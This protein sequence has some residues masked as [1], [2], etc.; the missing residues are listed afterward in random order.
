MIRSPLAFV[1]LLLAFSAS[2]VFAQ[3]GNIFDNLFQQQRQQQ[4]PNQPKADGSW[5]EETYDN[6]NC[7]G[8]ICEDTLACV[9]RPVDCPC[10]FP[11]SEIK[12]ILPGGKNY[13]CISKP[14][15][16][17]PK[18]RDCKFVEKAFKGLV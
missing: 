14:A 10:K 3:F 9:K 18:P 11:N 17:D 8:Y 5:F 6:Y 2:Q 7:N 16:N 15:D 13:V 12:C 4:Q 1:L